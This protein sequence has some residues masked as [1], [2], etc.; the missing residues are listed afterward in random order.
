MKKTYVW[1]DIAEAYGATSIVV[2]IYRDWGVK[3][4]GA[5]SI[6]VCTYLKL[7]FAEAQL[8]DSC[9]PWNLAHLPHQQRL[10]LNL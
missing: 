9:L 3:A 10:L 4:Y 1:L 6:V 7:D 8:I 2:C 5:T